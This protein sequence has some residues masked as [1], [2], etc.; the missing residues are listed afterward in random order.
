M[1]I[2]I[3][4]VPLALGHLGCLTP[5]APA[6]VLI[7][8]AYAAIQPCTAARPTNSILTSAMH[9]HD[10]VR[11]GDPVKWKGNEGLLLLFVPRSNIAG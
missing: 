10:G 3:V 7:R 6:A 2:R 1:I 11:S 8:D 4:L 5:K 9:E